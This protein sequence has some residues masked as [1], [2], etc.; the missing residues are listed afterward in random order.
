[1]Y[2]KIA[3]ALDGSPLAEKA[4]PLAVKL[5]KL[6]AARLLLLRVTVLPL[7]LEE[8]YTRENP[9]ELMP[10]TYLEKVKAEITGPAEYFRLAPDQVDIKVSRGKFTNE[11]PEVAEE[12]G[13]NLIVMTSHGL[14]G[15]S[16]LLMGSVTQQVLRNS[17]LPV[18]VLHPRPAKEPAGPVAEPISFGERPLT[19]AV[20]LDGEPASEA[21]LEPACQLAGQLHANIRLLRVVNSVQPILLDEPVVE[22]LYSQEDQSDDLR[23]RREEAAHYLARL[24]GELAA[25][26]QNVTFDTEVLSGYPAD[27]LVA[28]AG[29]TQPFLVA[30]ATHARGGVGR[31]LLGSVADEVMREAGCPVFMVHIPKDYEGWAKTSLASHTL[32]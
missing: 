17:R 14:G 27:K 6:T 26:W 31:I 29:R 10:L 20:P 12:E 24:R 2:T 8:A 23:Y 13:A 30:M 19:I 22:I 32:P 18:I 16:R 1:M 5:A 3:V 4:L 25:C 15:F 9:H 21:V 11:I 28:W 7:E